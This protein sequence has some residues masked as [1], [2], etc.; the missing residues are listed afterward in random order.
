MN[1]A[2]QMFVLCLL[3]LSTSFCL[4]EPPSRADSA[5]NAVCLPGTEQVK[6]NSQEGL[7]YR[8][9][10][11]KPEQPAP[12]AGYR[13]LVLLDGHSTFPAAVTLYG[14]Q[15]RASQLAP[16]IIVGVGYPSESRIDMPRRTFDLTPPAELE[17]LPPRRGGSGWPKHGGADQFITFLKDGLKPWLQERYSLDPTQEAIFGHSFGGLFVMHCLANAPESFDYYIAASPSLWW[18][19][20]AIGNPQQ[21]IDNQWLGKH[22]RLLIT[23]GG[24]ELGEDAGPASLLATT[25]ARKTFGNT[26]QFAERIQHLQTDGVPVQYKEFPGE[27]HGSV[28]PLAIN[29]ALRFALQRNKTSSP[30]Q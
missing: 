15:Q 12:E 9:L 1:T 28:T 5:S 20:Y 26:R 10:I 22:T 8:I 13:L 11:A 25:P 17:K 4:A 2:T 21:W 27:N 24:Q 16:T 30:E 29:E 19:D 7:E 18:N 3:L 14:M 6:L 23:V